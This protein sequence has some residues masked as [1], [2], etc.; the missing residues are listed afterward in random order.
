M[1]MIETETA[2]ALVSTKIRR[3]RSA[4]KCDVAL[5]KS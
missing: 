1:T 3:R 5:K 2:T 4:P